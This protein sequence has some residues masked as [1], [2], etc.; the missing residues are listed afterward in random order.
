[1]AL[2]RSCRIRTLARRPSRQRRGQSRAF[3]DSVI[4]LPESV[5][6]TEQKRVRGAWY[7]LIRG[8]NRFR[9]LPR[10]SAATQGQF[11]P[12]RHWDSRKT[13][14]RRSAPLD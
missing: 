13:Q 11:R 1:M 6:V 2:A 10:V 14:K 12:G 4:P 9:Q 3:D 5:F 8:K 7:N